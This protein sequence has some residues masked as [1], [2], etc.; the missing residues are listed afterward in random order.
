MHRALIVVA[1]AALLAA[2]GPGARNKAENKATA[3][4]TSANAV[5]DANPI[6]TIAIPAEPAPAEAGRVRDGER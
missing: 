1:G 3:A 5:P 4:E 2:C 6:A